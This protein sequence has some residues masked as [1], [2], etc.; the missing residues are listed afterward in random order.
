MAERKMTPQERYDANNCVRV[1]L[2]LN[3]KTD[4]D[5]LAKLDQVDSKQGYIKQL[6]RNDISERR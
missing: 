5:V 3:R 6:I 1:G 2:K 4:A